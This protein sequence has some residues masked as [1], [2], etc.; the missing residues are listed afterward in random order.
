MRHSSPEP[1]FTIGL[2]SML[3]RPS[4]VGV[5]MSGDM[6]VVTGFGDVLEILDVQHREAITV[7]REMVD[8]ILAAYGVR[9][10]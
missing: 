9:A 8:W 2:R 10:P 4:S 5:G 3:P 7:P 6:S 1:R